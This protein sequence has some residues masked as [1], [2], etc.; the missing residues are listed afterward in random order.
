MVFHLS[1]FSLVTIH[2]IT[3]LSITISL[4]TLLASWIKGAH[5]K[6]F[7]SQL[8]TSAGEESAYN[9]TNII[10]TNCGLVK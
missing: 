9:N 3:I 2:L 10:A 8:Q 4:E 7:F 6:W 1:A 5:N